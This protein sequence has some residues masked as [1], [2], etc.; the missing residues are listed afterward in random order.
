[1]ATQRIHVAEHDIRLSNPDKELYPDEHVSKGDVIEHYQAVADAMLPHLAGRP[2]TLR[3]YPDGIDAEG[4]F[5][6]SAS[7]YFPD[8][9]TTVDV[10]QRQGNGTVTHV[11]SDDV[12][13]LVYLANQA[14]IEHHIW[15]STVDKLDHPDRMVIDIDPPP[16]TPVTTLRVIARRLRNEFESIGLTPYVQATGGRGFHVVAPLDR[17]EDYAYVRELAADLA[18]HLVVQDPD[19]LTTAQ[20]KQRRGNRVF[21][22]VNR[23]AYGQ[24]FSCPYSLRAR[25][26][27]PVTTPLDWAELGRATPNGYDLHKI[28]QRLAR[29]KDPWSAMDSHA[30]APAAAREQLAARLKGSG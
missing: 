23:N 14:T 18:D 6:Q 16:D 24:T 22:D 2:L 26:G 17:S 9:L 11:T 27:A 25:P 7:S 13:T 20:R 21:L 30:A 28:R 3:R 8:W 5:Q 19:L 10:P 12:A 29:K 4:F 15:L 1:M